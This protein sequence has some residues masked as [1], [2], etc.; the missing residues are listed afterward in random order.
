[1]TSIS[2]ANRLRTRVETYLAGVF[3]PF[4]EERIIAGTIQSFYGW[5]FSASAERSDLRRPAIF[6]RREREHDAANIGHH[7]LYR[8]RGVLFFVHQ[9]V[10][11]DTV[12]LR[13]AQA[14]R[15]VARWSGHAGRS[16]VVGVRD[17][18]RN[19]VRH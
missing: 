17:L 11:A 10:G 14:T 7:R 16:I 3:H 18:G 15:I 5:F 9:H 12:S 6:C 2:A 13:E 4:P 1:M 8:T 19:G